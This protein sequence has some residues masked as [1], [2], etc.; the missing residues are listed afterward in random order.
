MLSFEM[1]L[2]QRVCRECDR[3][4]RDSLKLFS[5]RSELQFIISVLQTLDIVSKSCNNRTAVFIAGY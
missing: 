3:V 4:W 1:E 2:V 5:T